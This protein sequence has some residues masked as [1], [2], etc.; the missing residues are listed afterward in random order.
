[1]ADVGRLRAASMRITNYNKAKEPWDNHL[2]VYPL[3]APDGARRA[4]NARDARDR[5]RRW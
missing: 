5:C 4:T 3:S 2:R 1:M